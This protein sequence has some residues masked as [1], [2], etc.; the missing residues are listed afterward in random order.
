VRASQADPTLWRVG[1]HLDPLGFAP[2]ELYEHGHRFDDIDRR[3]RTLYVAEMVETCL[4]EVLADFRPNLAARRRFLERFGPDAAEDLPDVAVTAAWRRQNVL[5]PLTLELEGDLIDLT[6]IPT[7]QGIEERHQALL[8]AHDLQ[9]L[10]LHEITTSRRAVTQTIAGDLYDR[11]AAAVRFPSR[12]DG[13][14]CIAL[15]EGRGEPHAAGEPTPLTDP[16]PEALQKVCAT[17]KLDLEPAEAIIA[18]D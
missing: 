2:T 10:D 5:V 4:R 1:Y 9:H 13:N 3:F 8:L 11:G 17:W 7:R 14:A 18:A 12:L 15:F 6:D 16:A